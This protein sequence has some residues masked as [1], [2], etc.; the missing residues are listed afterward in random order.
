M[1][2]AAVRTVAVAAAAGALAACHVDGGNGNA[3]EAGAAGSIASTAGFRPLP[4]D[5]KFVSP[6][7][8]HFGK[9]TMKGAQLPN[10]EAILEPFQEPVRV[11]YARSLHKDKP[12]T[13]QLVVELAVSSAGNV[14]ETTIQSRAGI[15]DDV[16]A[17]TM[18]R[19]R[20]PAFTTNGVGTMVDVPIDFSVAPITAPPSAPVDGGAS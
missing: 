12:M 1:M 14:V 17:C 16:A 18:R 13:G 10:A 5:K 7:V 20:A 2:R 9:V 4:E 11:C 3:V 19:L 15:S 6:A 8:V